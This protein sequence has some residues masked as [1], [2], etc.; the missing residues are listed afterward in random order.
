[1]P[2]SSGTPRPSGEG[3]FV[4]LPCGTNVRMSMGL[5]PCLTGQA[6]A[7]GMGPNTCDFA[8]M[9]GPPALNGDV[10]P[11]ARSASLLCGRYER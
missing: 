11:S 6:M 7:P 10:H 3:D 1:M 4:N 2:E 9:S 8:A 5:G